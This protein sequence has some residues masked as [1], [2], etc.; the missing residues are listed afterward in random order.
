MR[1]APAAEKEQ[2]YK[3]ALAGLTTP[4]A[5]QAP[6]DWSTLTETG[7]DVLRRQVVT[8]PRAYRPKEHSYRP[9]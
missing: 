9:G 6:W 4:E 1:N 2:D 5:A 7:A 3:F 8:R